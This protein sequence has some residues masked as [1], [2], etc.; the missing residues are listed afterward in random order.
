MLIRLRR[1]QCWRVTEERHQGS[2]RHSTGCPKETK[3]NTAHARIA[4]LALK[5]IEPHFSVIRKA[6]TEYV[7]H[8]KSEASKTSG[9]FNLRIQAARSYKNDPKK[10]YRWMKKIQRR[11][12][13][14][15]MIITLCTEN[16]VNSF[17]RC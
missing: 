8:A 13:L 16:V 1:I 12:K 4:R 17:I 2:C 11:V 9:E 14:L 6:W 7:E 5:A 3:I 10:F 15:P